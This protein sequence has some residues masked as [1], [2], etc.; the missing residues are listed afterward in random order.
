MNYRAGNYGNSY[1]DPTNNRLGYSTVSKGYGYSNRSISLFYILRLSKLRSEL[2]L[3]L[4]Y[5]G[6]LKKKVQI[7]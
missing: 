7:S 2:W 1:L 4:I 3:N 5:V 6:K